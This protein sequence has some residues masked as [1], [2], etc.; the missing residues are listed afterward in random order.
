MPI[1]EKYAARTAC[2]DHSRINTRE[3]RGSLRGMFYSDCEA[4]RNYGCKFSHTIFNTKRILK[5]G[6]ASQDFLIKLDY[7]YGFERYGAYEGWADGWEVTVN[8]KNLAPAVAPLK[9]T[10]CPS[11]YSWQN[12]D[13]D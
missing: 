7:G 4:R 8:G 5:L 1:N 10:I 6:G 11:L 2:R 12:M 13:W 9:Y 3:L